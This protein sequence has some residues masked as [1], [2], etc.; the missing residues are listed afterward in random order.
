MNR[1]IVQYRLD[2]SFAQGIG[3]CLRGFEGNSDDSQTDSQFTNTL[4]DQYLRLHLNITG[5]L[6][7]AIG[8]SIENGG[9]SETTTAQNRHTGQLPGRG[10]HTRQV[11]RSRS[12]PAPKSD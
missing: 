3:D 12:D 5:P 7:D 11:R 4:L 8:I 9:E 1:R 6:P 10:C 2:A